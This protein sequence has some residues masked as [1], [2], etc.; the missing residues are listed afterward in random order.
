MTK[1]GGACSAPFSRDGPGVTSHYVPETP[2]FSLSLK[3]FIR[4]YP[5]FYN[6]TMF[7]LGWAGRHL[8]NCQRRH[9]EHVPLPPGTKRDPQLE[10][11]IDI[12]IYKR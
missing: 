3:T 10:I 7:R 8:C 11:Y 12:C 2:S 6:G 4:S 9:F 1:G 5:G